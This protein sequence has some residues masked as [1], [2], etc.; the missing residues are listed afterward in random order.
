MNL[1]KTNKNLLHNKQTHCVLHNV[2]TD[3]SKNLVRYYIYRNTILT[4]EG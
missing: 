2:N 3:L 1:T 4:K